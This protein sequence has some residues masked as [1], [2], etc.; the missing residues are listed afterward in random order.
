MRSKKKIA[1]VVTIIII[2]AMGFLCIKKL[3]SKTTIEDLVNIS[4]LSQEFMDNYL[5]DV[6]KIKDEDKENL[7][8]VTSK[9]QIKNTYGAS[10]IISAP[11]NQYYLQYESEDDKDI[12]LKKF[13]DNKQVLSVQ[14]NLIYHLSNE[15]IESN[16]N[17]WG[18]QKSGFDHAKNVIEDSGRA[19][20][21]NVAIIDSGC[22]ME[23]FNENYNG[24]IVDTYNIY[25]SNSE[26]MYDD[27]GH[28]T[29]IAGT[30]AESTPSNVKIIPIK[31]TNGVQMTTV[32]IISA[33][34]YIVYNNKANVVNMSFGT[35][36][37]DD[38]LYL[39]I[40]AA[41]QK[42]IICVAAAGNKN[43]SDLPYPASFDKVS[44]QNRKM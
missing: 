33:I 9:K 21:I 24:K 37:Y 27:E 18:V 30:I 28:G 23:L 32:D 17:S 1:I 16:Y 43:T 11:N 26:S 44:C 20:N 2:S 15:T 41:E 14:E 42:N 40:E 6:K 5:S 7:L 13:N 35:Y 8:I 4:S 22:D 36:S 25:D 31:I 19:E 38:S 34:N 39:T 12:A 10:K 29:H 3:K